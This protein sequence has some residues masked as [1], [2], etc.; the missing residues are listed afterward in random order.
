MCHAV[1]GGV[2]SITDRVFGG[3]GYDR[4]GGYGRPSEVS[5]GDSMGKRISDSSAS[6]EARRRMVERQLAARNVAD[7]NVLRA[8]LRVP[9]ESFVPAEL[10]DSAYQDAPLPIGSGQTIS[11]PYIVAVMAEALE[12]D[13]DSRVLEIGTGSGYSAAVLAEIAGEVYTIERREDLAETAARRLADLGY[14]SVHVLH[15]DGSKGLPEAAPFD[16]I[17]VTAAAA[18]VPEDLKR[19]LADGGRLVVPVGGRD[20]VQR[21][22]RFRRVGVTGFRREVLMDVRFVPLLPEAE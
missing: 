22:I 14:R 10:R 19:Q 2:R 15:G 8:M 1:G 9:R 7:P 12:I 13:R 3:P 17:A 5:R 18:V 11:Q 21:L 16:A 4:N 20:D 6:D